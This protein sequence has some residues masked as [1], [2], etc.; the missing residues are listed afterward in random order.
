MYE[1]ILVV[2][3]IEDIRSLLQEALQANGYS[4]LEAADGREALSIIETEPPDLVIL[5]IAMPVMSGFQVL[6]QLRKNSDIPVIM[7]SARTDTVDKVESLELGADDYITKPFEIAEMTARVEAVLRRRKTMSRVIDKVEFN[8]GQLL[9][10]LAKRRVTLK[11]EAVELTPKEYELL[12]ELVLN[13]GTVLEYQRI[14][15]AV[16]GKEYGNAKE[17]VQVTLKRLRAKIE[18][19]PG[20]PKYILTIS[21]VGYRFKEIS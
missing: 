11:G 7:L 4:T 8:D 20:N 17:L 6:R 5:D 1:K 16:W 13:A 21:G 14:L 12:R 2:D 3:D 15:D 19:D 18:V 10:N 9:I